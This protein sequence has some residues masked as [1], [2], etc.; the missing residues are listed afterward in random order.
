MAWRSV[1]WLCDCAGVLRQ[2][3]YVCC[4]DDFVEKVEGRKRNVQIGSTNSDEKQKNP[5]E[6]ICFQEHS[7][8]ILLPRKL[9]TPS[10]PSPTSS[11][12]V[13]RPHRAQTHR[14]PDMRETLAS[15]PPPFHFLKLLTRATTP[16]PFSCMTSDLDSITLGRTGCNVLQHLVSQLSFWLADKRTTARHLYRYHCER[17]AWATMRCADVCRS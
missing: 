6:E 1:A 12:S 4:E 5:H 3:K 7:H 11:A 8:P 15:F 16:M 10:I 17:I 2:V 9:A 13:S 14:C